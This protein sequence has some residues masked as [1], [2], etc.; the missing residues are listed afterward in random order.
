[1]SYL[2]SITNEVLFDDVAVQLLLNEAHLQGTEKYQTV[3]NIL[4]FWENLKS[5]GK[6]FMQLLQKDFLKKVDEETSE[7]DGYYEIIKEPIAIN[8]LQVSIQDMM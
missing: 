6:G 7:A 4:D 2:S 3:F 8:D 1:M 5:I